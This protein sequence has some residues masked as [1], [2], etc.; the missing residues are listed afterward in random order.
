M[1]ADAILTEPTPLGIKCAAT[2]IEQ[3]RRNHPT[4]SVSTEQLAGNTRKS[5]PLKLG[6]F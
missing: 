5:L 4:A 1:I 2:G 6:S 3:C